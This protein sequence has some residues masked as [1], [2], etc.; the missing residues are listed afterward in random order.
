MLQ[1]FKVS[2]QH[3]G[4]EYVQGKVTQVLIFANPPKELV[5]SNHNHDDHDDNEEHDEHD[6]QHGGAEYV[7]GKVTEVQMLQIS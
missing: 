2:A 7:Q 5:F 4:V 1:A 6:V 3:G